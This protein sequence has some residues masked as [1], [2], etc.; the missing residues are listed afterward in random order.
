MKALRNKLY[1]EIEVLE[2]QLKGFD[3]NQFGFSNDPKSIEIN[4]K[5]DELELK[6]AET[7]LSKSNKK[8]KF[9]DNVHCKD[10]N[11]SGVV[12]FESHETIY[13]HVKFVDGST[14]VI[15]KKDLELINND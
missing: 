15:N 12:T 14:K 5:I 13:V 4:N 6:I 7:W 11:K 9:G 2:K 10:I 3:T 8:I 1:N